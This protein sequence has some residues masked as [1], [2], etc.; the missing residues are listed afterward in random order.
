M[1]VSGLLHASA[2]FPPGK[3]PSV[4]TEI[5]IKQLLLLLLGILMLLLVIILLVLLPPEFCTF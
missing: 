2:A 3:E 4:P 1:D 5:I